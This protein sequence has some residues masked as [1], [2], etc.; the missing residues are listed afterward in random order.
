MRSALPKLLFAALVAVC[1]LLAAPAAQADGFSDCVQACIDQFDEDK[2]E[3][4]V[5]LAEELAALDQQALDCYGLGDPI[6]VQL[7][8]R[9]INIKRYQAQSS[10]RR[11]I[12]F[13]NT[14]AYNCYRE[15]QQSAAQP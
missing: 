9:D 11:C 14:A 2:Q 7:C 6:S 10:H 4:D 15:C 1:A 5:Q 13:A 8:L 3:C 12:S